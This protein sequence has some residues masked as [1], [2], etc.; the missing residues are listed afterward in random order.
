MKGEGEVRTAGWW[1]S[2]MVVK[3]GGGDEAR[4]MLNT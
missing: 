2:M 3:R 4:P 1:S